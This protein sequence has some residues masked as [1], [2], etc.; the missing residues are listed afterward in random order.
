MSSNDC[1]TLLVRPDW[2]SESACLGM[3]PSNFFIDELDPNYDSKVLIA[4][5]V[6]FS[7]PVKSECFNEAKARNEEFGIWGGVN[8][9]EE[10]FSW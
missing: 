2:W 5:R 10:D 7:C 9:E 8:V 4:K 1:L 3:H 6:C